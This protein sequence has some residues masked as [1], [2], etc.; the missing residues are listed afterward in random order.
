MRRSEPVDR[1]WSA[2]CNRVAAFFTGTESIFLVEQVDGVLPFR[3][4][5]CLVAIFRCTADDDQSL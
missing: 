4:T 3:T 1:E 5:G 2:V